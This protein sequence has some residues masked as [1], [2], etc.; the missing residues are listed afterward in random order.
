LTTADQTASPARA[1]AGFV[2]RAVAFVIDLVILNGVLFGGALVVGLIIEAFGRFSPHLDLGSAVLAGVVWSIT[3][4][5]YFIAWWSLTG[6]TPGMRALGVKVLTITGDRL[7]PRRGL[8][9]AIAMVIAAIPF[10]TG[11]LLILVRD[12]RE[13]LHDLIART[14]VVYVE[15]DRPPVPHRRA[16]VV[17]GD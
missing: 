16:P 13:G 11:Y 6:Q 1:Y 7:R 10:F 5:I 8:L 2:T 17:Q 3:F 14:V 12:R 15:R 9:R 4:A